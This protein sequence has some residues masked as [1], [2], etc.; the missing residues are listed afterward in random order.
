MFLIPFLGTVCIIL[1]SLWLLL[2]PMKRKAWFFGY[3][4]IDND[5]AQE[6]WSA[7]NKF[8]YRNVLFSGIC[9][10]TLT[11]IVSLY[12]KEYAIYFWLF[13]QASV[14][15]FLTFAT[16]LYLKSKFDRFGNPKVKA[17]EE[18]IYS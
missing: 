14:I 6:V 12:W 10:I 4:I 16:E 18:E 11:Y 3:W 13:F 15:I 1:V 2:I 17:S 7:A 5:N 9:S 8:F